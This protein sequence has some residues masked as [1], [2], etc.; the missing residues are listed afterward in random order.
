MA[1]EGLP[2]CSGRTQHRSHLGYS[3]A[4][5]KQYFLTLFP[6]PLERKEEREE[7]SPVADANDTSS[8]GGHTTALGT[9]S[10]AVSPYMPLGFLC[11]SWKREAPSPRPQPSQL[12]Y[13]HYKV[14]YMFLERV[15]AVRVL[16]FSSTDEIFGGRKP[17]NMKNTDLTKCAKN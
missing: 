8:R 2:F 14:L 6:F 12:G 7:E 3:V 4:S 15:N 5:I 1:V 10:A 16:D 17:Q 9:S 13:L 11:S